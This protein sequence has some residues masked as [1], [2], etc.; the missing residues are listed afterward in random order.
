M[1]ALSPPI[2][3]AIDGRHASNST[4]CYAFTEAKEAD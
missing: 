3:V 4:L 2:A 1:V